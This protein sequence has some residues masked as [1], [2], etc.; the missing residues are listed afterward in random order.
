MIIHNNYK[1]S[2]V[3]GCDDPPGTE[4]FSSYSSSNVA[5]SSTSKLSSKKA[6]FFL[7][8]STAEVGVNASELLRFCIFIERLLNVTSGCSNL[9][10]ASFLPVFF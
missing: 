4:L 6:D 2:L 3:E 1:L 7:D 9:L 5:F 10:A 8:L